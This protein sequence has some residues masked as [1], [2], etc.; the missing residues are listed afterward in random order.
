MKDI[1]DGTFCTEICCIRADAG[2]ETEASAEEEAAAVVL[3]VDRQLPSRSTEKIYGG[4]DRDMEESEE[5]L[6]GRRRRRYVVEF[7]LLCCSY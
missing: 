2:L 3:V 1:F 4:E 5:L 7:P 6:H